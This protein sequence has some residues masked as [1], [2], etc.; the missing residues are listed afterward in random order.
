MG[1]SD[2]ICMHPVTLMQSWCSVIKL[3]YNCKLFYWL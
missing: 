3:K 1:D 2:A